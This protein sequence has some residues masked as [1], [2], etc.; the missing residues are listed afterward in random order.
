MAMS[1]QQLTIGSRRLATISMRTDT[2][3]PALTAQT[4]Q[5]VLASTE[6]AVGYTDGDSISV[7]GAYLGQAGT[8]R[9]GALLTADKLADYRGCKVV[10]IRFALSQSIG[11]TAAYL[12][13][14]TDNQAYEVVE[15]NVR[16]TADGWN[17]MRL[18]SGQEYTITANEDLLFGFDY[19]ETADMA[20]NEEG[21]LCFYTPSM[22]NENASLL[23]QNGAFYS[24][25]G[26][27]NLCVQL[28]IDV[29][30]LPKK[31]VR[32]THLLAGNK[33][34]VK[35][36]QID[37][38]VQFS[39]IGTE[40]ISST[41]FGYRFDDGAVTYVDTQGTVKSGSVG[42]VN[43]LIK[44]P[45]DMK[46]GTH[47][48]TIFADQIDGAP[49]TRPEGDTLTSRFVVYTP[50]K[51]FKRQ[52][53]YVEQYNSQDSYLS[54]MVNDEMSKAA[55]DDSI[56]LVNTYIEGEPLSVDASCYLDTL[57]AY[58][59]PCFTVDRFYFLGENTI[60]FDVNDYASIMPSLVS[61]A[62]RM[63]VGEARMNPAFATLRLTPSYDKANRLLTLDI[64][65]KASEEAS[66]IF[67]DLGLTVMLTEDKVVSQQQY[68][69]EQT[70]KLQNDKNYVH[71]QVL[72]TYLT[73]PTG[74]RIATDD[75]QFATRL[76]YTLPD[77][78]K[79]EDLKAV[80]LVS[81]YLPLVD[82][83][84]VL[85]ADI[86]NA[87]S[88][89]VTAGGEAGIKALPEQEGNTQ[90]DGIYSLNGIRTEGRLTKGI[91]IVRKAGKSQKVV[92]P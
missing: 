5:R 68:Y 61:D 90:A 86:L 75:G 65:G 11:K 80:A 63:L 67:G 30:N 1:A 19:V 81:K 10:G 25:T 52:Q 46:A 18:N 40:D 72:R 91:Y 34:K 4:P 55:T 70:K 42:S 17:E 92:I 6:R 35:D 41:R 45:A 8:Y 83:S 22:D 84:N 33:Y 79:P 26:A 58:T 53:T 37:A 66:A 54:A 59:H 38:F 32:L 73:T 44:M 39:N 12:Y 23:L 47:R 88:I 16:R 2:P 78:W 51:C 69:D 20:Q 82:D 29:T 15:N 64:S 57:Y 89:S 50:E 60:A 49:A 14:V 7:R 21:A 13:K 28:I 24:L 9:V 31:D 3:A 27:G 85:D 76:T 87:A 71:N 56:C 77:G 62:V 48:L 36:E 43:P 74:D